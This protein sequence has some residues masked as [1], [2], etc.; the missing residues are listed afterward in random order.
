[1]LEQAQI[2]SHAVDEIEF[3]ELPFFDETLDEL[4]GTTIDESRTPL[5]DELAPGNADRS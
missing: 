3:P 2:N 1:M 5:A 4:N